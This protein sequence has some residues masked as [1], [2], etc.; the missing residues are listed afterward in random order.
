VATAVRTKAPA[1]QRSESAPES[2]DIINSDRPSSREFRI[3]SY[4]TYQPEA[5]SIVTYGT[6]EPTANSPAEGTT[7]IPHRII[8]YED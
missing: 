5:R 8:N 6:R 1:A 7:P 2:H 3:I 4:L